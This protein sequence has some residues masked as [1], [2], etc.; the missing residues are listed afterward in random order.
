MLIDLPFEIWGCLIGVVLFTMI[1]K[2]QPPHVQHPRVAVKA[3]PIRQKTHKAKKVK[4]AKKPKRKKVLT[5]KPHVNTE[6]ENRILDQYFI[7]RDYVHAA[8]KDFTAD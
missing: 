8:N 6:Y 1:F 4:K 5:T 2:T 7:K 3:R